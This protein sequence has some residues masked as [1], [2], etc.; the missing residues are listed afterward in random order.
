MSWMAKGGCGNDLMI[1]VTEGCWLMMHE[2]L[3]FGQWLVGYPAAF[4]L[5][6]LG[7]D[8]RDD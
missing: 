5:V 8:T 1:D 6:A 3:R 4:S 7:N 2:R